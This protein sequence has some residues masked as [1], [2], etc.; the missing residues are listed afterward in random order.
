MDQRPHLSKEGTSHVDRENGAA[1]RVFRIDLDHG[2]R[3][4]VSLP[5]PL[6]AKKTLA[7]VE[8]LRK[9]ADSL[10]AGAHP[11]V[12]EAVARRELVLLGAQIRKAFDCPRDAEE[13]LA[14]LQTC[15]DYHEAVMEYLGGQ[16]RREL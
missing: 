6:E 11:L 8:S 7:M 10:E 12:S 1:V 5:A 9:L 2:E 16:A 14:F 3:L 13:S 4:L 15:R